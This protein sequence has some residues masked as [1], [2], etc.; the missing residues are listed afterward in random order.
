MRRMYSQAELSAII[1]EVF[2]SDVASGQ[3]DLPA[4]IEEALPE[5]DFSELDLVVKSV[6]AETLEQSEP[7]WSKEFNFSDQTNLTVT[8][9]YNRFEVINGILW[10]I[11]NLK[12]EVGA[13]NY[14]AGGFGQGVNIE[15][16]ADKIY[17]L[18]G[19]PVSEEAQ[20]QFCPITC[21][22]MYIGE[23]TSQDLLTLGRC[24]IQR[25]T[26][27]ADRVNVSLRGIPTLTAGKTYYL[28]ARV[29]LSLI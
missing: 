26:S 8:N 11:V 1:K 16:I 14:T 3:I 21:A 12:L 28:T 22:P 25:A 23:N 18:N 15:E 24:L 2:L 17:D 20:V 19:D 9:T 5:V 4:L 27:Q 29:P 6:E 7:N 10:I 13:S